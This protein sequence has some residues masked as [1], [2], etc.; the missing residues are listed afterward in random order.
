MYYDFFRFYVY[1]ELDD[2]TCDSGFPYADSQG[3]FCDH[4]RGSEVDEPLLNAYVLNRCHES[5][6][7]GCYGD[8]KSKYN[9]RECKVT[10]RRVNYFN[11]LSK[12][13]EICDE[14][15]EQS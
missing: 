2:Y 1:I 4:F 9:C 10:E 15:Y 14:I 3:K 5:C 8:S 7:N 11:T 12:T 6:A 13:E